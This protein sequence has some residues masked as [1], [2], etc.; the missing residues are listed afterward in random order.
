MRT[1]VHSATR[2]LED[3]ERLAAR[4]GGPMGAI[5][6]LCNRWQVQELALFDS[7]LRDDFGP[8]TLRSTFRSPG[9]RFATTFRP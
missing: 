6:A 5:E 2:A 8:Y 4:I 1:S 9:T 7:V 3:R